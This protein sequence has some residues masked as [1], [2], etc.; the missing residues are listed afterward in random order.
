MIQRDFLRI[1]ALSGVAFLGTRELRA[2]ARKDPA[3]I[4]VMLPV[5]GNDSFL[6]A[7]R[8]GLVDL[9][10]K[11]DRDFVLEVR[12]AD[13]TVA[14][15]RQFGSELA[16]LSLDVMVT[17]STAAATALGEASRGTPVI[18]VGTFDPVAA[19]LVASMEHPGGILTGIAGFQ[20]E[21]AASW[22][23]ILREMAP[24]VERMGIFSNPASVSKAALSGWRTVAAQ[25]AEVYDVTVESIADIASTV[26]SVAK[27]PRAGMIVVPHTFPFA[28]RK[29]VV[30]AM[31]DHKV[32]A[33]YGI[34]EMV[35]AGGLISY[36]QDLG[37]QWR[38][39]A[40][41]VDKVLKGAK[42]SDI[43]ARYANKYSLA[44]NTRAAQAI[45]LPAP[46]SLIAKADEVVD[47]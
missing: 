5:P 46:S 33:I 1:S 17:A 24:R 37:A 32:P 18:F 22:V 47:Q 7:F 26:A 40:S 21:V 38:M 20:N 41:Y 36:G 31:A 14:Q 42:P 35:R 12:R 11:P 29:P 8:T 44:I 13:G 19:G 15:F 34:V 4:G 9:G 2:Q 45:G 39:A 23:S 25:S 10:L 3:R 30:Q 6:E 16:A 27:D 43:P 28:N